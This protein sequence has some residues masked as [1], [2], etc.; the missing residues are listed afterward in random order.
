MNYIS[1]N[2]LIGI[3]FTVVMLLLAFYSFMAIYSLLRFGR[4][5]IIGAVVSLVYLVLVFML[6][7]H[8]LIMVG[9]FPD[10]IL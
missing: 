2:T 3:A 9:S 4:S 10:V 6:F 5:R 7:V 8:A 1:I